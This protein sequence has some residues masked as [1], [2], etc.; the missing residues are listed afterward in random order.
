LEDAFP[1]PFPLAAAAAAAAD[2][3]SDLREEAEESGLL[4]VRRVGGAAEAAELMAMF[5]RGSSWGIVRRRRPARWG[6]AGG[7]GASAPFLS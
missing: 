7:A 6:A 5:C 1:F 4:R 3:S 2:G